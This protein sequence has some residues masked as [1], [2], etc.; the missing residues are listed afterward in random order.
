MKPVSEELP[1]EVG[2]I[3]ESASGVAGGQLLGYAEVHER[4]TA[5]DYDC[6]RSRT[7]QHPRRGGSRL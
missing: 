1:I 2:Q 6:A 5:N 3:L 4:P 7:H